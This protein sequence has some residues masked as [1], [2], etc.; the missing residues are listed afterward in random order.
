MAQAWKIKGVATTKLLRWALLPGSTYYYKPSCGKRGRKPS[1]HTV[2]VEGEVKENQV[3]VHIIESTLSHEFCCYGYQ[4]MTTELTE[5][6]FIINHK[7]VYRLMK[8]HH[9]LYN[10]RIQVHGSPRSFVRFRRIE[11]LRPLQYLCMDIKYVHIHGQGRNALLL[12]IMDVYTRKVLTHM[13][14]FSIKK[15]DVLMLL[16]LLLVQHH[17]EGMT[18]RNDNGS[19][20][21]ASAVRQYLKGKGIYQ[22]FT[23]VATPQDNGYIES[24]HASLQREVVD[25]F[26]FEN[27]EEAQS[28]I[29]R[30]YRWYNEKRRH[31]SLK[32]GTPVQVWNQYFNPW[33]YK[34]NNPSLAQENEDDRLNCLEKTLQKIGG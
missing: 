12:T 3:V 6:G 9:L 15:G 24:L 19:Q 33:P 34:T 2:T 11:A 30:Y 14:R 28:V 7:K 4:Q 10:C 27:L 13:L 17:P 1:T 16:S 29:A 5:T 25:R 22:E 18:L 31:W 32:G 8:E 23:H 26:E 21:I 20:F